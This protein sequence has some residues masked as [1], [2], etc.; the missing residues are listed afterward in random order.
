MP[1]RA[2][3]LSRLPQRWSGK[4]IEVH[5]VMFLLPSFMMDNRSN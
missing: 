2:A 4:Q 3:V 1:P 5:G